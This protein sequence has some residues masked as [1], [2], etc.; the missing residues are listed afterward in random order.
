MKT[1]AEF[2]ESAAAIPAAADVVSKV[3]PAAA[4]AVGA[5]GTMMQARKK[6]KYQRKEMKG[7]VGD[8]Q[9]VNPKLLDAIR[10]KQKEINTVPSEKP[11]LDPKKNRI[12]DYGEFQ[13][14][15]PVDS[16]TRKRMNAPENQFNS[17][18]PLGEEAPTNNIGGGKI[19]GTVEAGDDPPV[20]P[21]GTLKKKKR[22]IYGGR[23]SR[24]MWMNNK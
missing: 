13:K 21:L 18:N 11:N 23:G 14:T 7:K 9:K 1:F 8:Q 12:T 15:K 5:V 22:Y 3:L 4:A 16:K 10:K 17:Y 2:Q 20:T 24:K 6:G 19:A